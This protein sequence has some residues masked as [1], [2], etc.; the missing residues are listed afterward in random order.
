MKLGRRFV[1]HL[2]RGRQHTPSVFDKRLSALCTTVCPAHAGV[3]LF[4][5]RR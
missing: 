1:I 3:A 2:L 5:C 4:R